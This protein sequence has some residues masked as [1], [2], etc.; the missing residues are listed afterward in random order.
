MGRQLLA[1]R[2]SCFAVIS[3]IET[4]LR[5][6]IACMAVEMST[7]DILP[8]DS[9]NA[10]QRRFNLDKQLSD[11][12][13]ANSDLDLLHYTDFADI[14]KVLNKFCDRFSRYRKDQVQGLAKEL[15]HLTPARNRVCHSRPLEPEDFSSIIEFAQTKVEH[16]KDLPFTDLGIVL[17]QLKEDPSS[18]LGVP[19]PQYWDTEVCRINHNLPLPDF[20]ETGFLGRLKD[21]RQLRSHLRSS[22]PVV[23]VVGEG[24]VGKTALVLRC[25][26]DLLEDESEPLFDSIV[27]T[28]SK[29]KALTTAG[30]AQIR[31]AIVSTLGVFQ[32]VA[33]AM[34][35]P[36]APICRDQSALLDEIKQFM[37]AFR[38]LIVIDN[39]ETLAEREFREFLSNIP[40]GS[41]V[42]IT[43]RLGLGEIELRYKLDVLDRA[44]A[45]DLVRKHASS[46]NLA[47]L[48]QADEAKIDRYCTSLHDNP[49][50]IKWFVSSVALG[51]FPENLVRRD[52]VDF[53][54]ALKFCFENLFE[55]LSET[56]K[57]V[58]HILASAKKP[59]TTAEIRFITSALEKA[60][61]IVVD[62]EVSMLSLFRSSIVRRVSEKGTN[63][64][65]HTL[66]ES[67]S[68]YIALVCP[69]SRTVF[70]QVQVKLRELTRLVEVEN[71]KRKTYMYDVCALRPK[72]RDDTIAAIYL[73]RAMQEC[74]KQTEKSISEAKG[75]IAQAKDMSP[76]YSEVY[77]ISGMVE[78][79]AG[80]PYL[81]SEEYSRSIELDPSC[82]INRYAYARFLLNQI[83]DFDIALVQIDEAVRLDPDARPLASLRASVLSR[84][85]RFSESAEIY[86]RILA[87]RIDIE[88]RWRLATVCQCASN[89]KK[90]ADRD[91]ALNEDDEFVTHI[92]KARDILESSFVLQECDDKAIDLYSRCIDE[93]LFFG[94]KKRDAS[95]I[96][97][98]VTGVFESC[99]IAGI[100]GLNLSALS[101]MRA[102]MP[103]SYYLS[104]I[105]R[106]DGVFGTTE[107]HAL[108][109]GEID[110]TRSSPVRTPIRVEYGLVRT[111]I[112]NYGF[113]TGD[114]SRD[115]FFHRSSLRNQRDWQSMCAGTRVTFLMGRNT[116]GPC[117]VDVRVV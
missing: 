11:G 70:Q 33:S 63:A 98:V 67:A 31:D 82:V 99:R 95:F 37:G 42:L 92:K 114:D 29:T 103:G 112:E 88:K 74:R 105:E 80:N 20:D 6:A 9:R 54:T 23:S 96:D 77:R 55:R 15:E 97:D 12:Q 65:L 115:W 104:I 43:S 84:L 94:L 64:F 32:N 81:A 58:V 109:L 16:F 18:L 86:E 111:I 21:R 87:D 60:G 45:I 100:K 78:A 72:S 14:A 89:Y 24:G 36:N 110:S 41:K 4:D 34:T 73:R 93:M 40:Q 46:M 2:S 27:W 51:A 8:S 83:E 69:P 68:D 56:D 57:T 79:D 66:T 107:S 75:L 26:Y 38:V 50:L 102:E 116:M 49:L 62:I 53:K 10:A 28:T 91:L 106:S 44:T 35:L 1:T 25:L 5:N 48:R 17:R 90:W 108:A 101:K 85:G 30:V 61:G 52:A 22:H 59:L 71:L 3:A 13:C 76:T 117:A 47:I 19:I 7:N 113:I 39:F